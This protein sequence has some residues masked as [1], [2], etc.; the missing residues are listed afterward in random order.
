[1]SRSFGLVD[2]K[3]AEANFFL[4]KLAGAGTNFFETRCYFSAFVAA[5]RSV[6]FSLQAVMADIDGFRDW[7]AD[8]QDTL[9]MDEL[10]R[11]FHIARTQL[12]HLGISPVNA[13]STRRAHDSTL[14]VQCHFISGQVEQP[15]VA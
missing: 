12:Q 6:T 14:Q 8:K 1:M 2:E 4:E 15:R 10:P 3:L 11:F 13:G 9:R 7:Y 5:A